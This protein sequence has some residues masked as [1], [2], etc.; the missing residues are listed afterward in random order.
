MRLT[1]VNSLRY[2]RQRGIATVE[3]ALIFPLMMIMAFAIID[4]GR[5][6]QARI[7]AANLAREGGSLGS[8]SIQSSPLD[9]ITMLQDG[10]SP[11]DMI[12]NGKIYITRISAGTSAANPDPYVDFSYTASSGGLSVSSTVG[13][14]QTNLGLT[15]A[16]YSHLEFDDTPGKMTSDISNVTVVEVFY[17]YT[18]LTPLGRFVPGLF[19][20]NGGEI[21]LSKAV[22]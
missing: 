15:S 5:L 19:T 10:A 11:L 18:P 1:Q 17:K 12:N 8:R 13:A 6:I 20:D 21:I 22:F 7:I 4:F 3:L 9:L 14:G 16:L 2:A